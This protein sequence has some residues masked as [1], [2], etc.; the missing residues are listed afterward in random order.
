PVNESDFTE[1]YLSVGNDHLTGTVQFQGSLYSDAARPIIDQQLGVSQGY[2]TYRF[3][4]DLIDGVKTRFKVKGG[5]FW[6]RFGYIPKYDTYVFGRTHQMGEQVRMEVEKDKFTV[7]LLDGV[8]THLEDVAS[9]EGLTL[10]HYAS[11]G[12]SYANTIE[13]GVYFMN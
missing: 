5:A 8:G 2:L 10:L 11:A 1:L 3:A 7:W 9:N 12:V 4:P 13:A 6:D